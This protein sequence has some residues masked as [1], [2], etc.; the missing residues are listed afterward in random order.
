MGAAPSSPAGPALPKVTPPTLLGGDSTPAL[1]VPSLHDRCK[2]GN[3][4]LPDAE[5]CR[6]CGATRPPVWQGICYCGNAFRADEVFCRKCG[7]PAEAMTL[8]AR[9]KTAAQERL[10][11]S[12]SDDPSSF[13]A[14]NVNAKLESEFAYMHSLLRNRKFVEVVFQEFRDFDIDSDGTLDQEEVTEAVPKMVLKHGWKTKE[15]VDKID[16]SELTQDFFRQ[17]DRDSNALVSMDEFLV[18]T[19]YFHY[20]CYQKKVDVPEIFFYEG[21]KPPAQVVEKESTVCQC[22]VFS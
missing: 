20:L 11:W 2:C 13:E 5:F 1:K 18:Y 17:M 10:K 15:E 9:L 12:R 7:A 19:S 21:K 4:F 14:W 16:H 8:L 3:A 6:M 22:C